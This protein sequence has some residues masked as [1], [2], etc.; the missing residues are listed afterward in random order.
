M[1]TCQ[2]LIISIARSLFASEE[3]IYGFL[4]ISI[5]NFIFESWFAHLVYGEP[6]STSNVF[7]CLRSFPCRRLTRLQWPTIKRHSLATTC[8]IKLGKLQNVAEK[9]GMSV[10]I[11][12]GRFFFLWA[13]ATFLR[14]MPR[15]VFSFR[16]LQL[17]SCRLATVHFRQS[18]RFFFPV[19]P[20]PP[21]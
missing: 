7:I 8:C 20:W 11:L 17:F 5:L 12:M 19:K 4:R 15:S 1:Q 3:P 2:S 18:I 13:I 14:A 10:C 6:G 21:C 16:W 9:H